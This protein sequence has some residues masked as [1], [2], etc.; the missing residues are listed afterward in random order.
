MADDAI[1]NAKNVTQEDTLYADNITEQVITS[2][3][4]STP[5]HETH[6]VDTE[7]DSDTLEYMEA[8]FA[9]QYARDDEHHNDAISC[10][11]I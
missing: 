8:M 5:C 1:A 3:N 9:L 6:S 10:A 11:E 4:T 2:T 7:M